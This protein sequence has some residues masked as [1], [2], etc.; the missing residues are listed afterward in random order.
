MTL[1]PP[2]TPPF[3]STYGNNPPEP[4][5][6]THSTSF[7][8]APERRRHRPPRRLA[9]LMERLRRRDRQIVP[10]AA[11]CAAAVDG[12]HPE[13]ALP[14]CR[15][16]RGPGGGC[17]RS[18]WEPDPRSLGLRSHQRRCGC[19]RCFLEAAALRYEACRKV[20]VV[21]DHACGLYHKA[22]SL[23]CHL[24][25]CPNCEPQRQARIRRAFAD[26][27]REVPADELTAL[28]LT[29]VNPPFGALAAGLRRH[30]RDLARLRRTPVF[31][32]GKCA[33][34][35]HPAGYEHRR[36]P[37]GL[38][39]TECP[40]SSRTPATWNLHTNAIVHARFVAEW[41]EL[42]WW[43]RRAT[44]A[45]HRR[46]PGPCPRH[47]TS[48]LSVGGYPRRC[49]KC[50][51]PQCAG[52][53]WDL[54]VERLRKLEETIKYV[55]KPAALLGIG[56]APFVEFLLARRHMKFASSWGAWYRRDLAPDDDV[57]EERVRV[58]L[59]PWA[60]VRLPKRCAVVGRDAE[61]ESGWTELVARAD[62]E[63]VNG[64]LVWRGEPP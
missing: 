55:T 39:S 49:P 50:G 58:W 5:G 29:A 20:R 37:A 17:R 14:V 12:R 36:V 30:K 34:P 28:V 32:G 41:D 18:W 3:F 51:V 1:S 9:P 43:W 60:S 10:M 46:C 8:W 57:A 59:D 42:S 27:L 23:S 33:W 31:A 25:G 2:L 19:A 56:L 35:K 13:L 64:A 54:R 53:A 7:P 24:P 4:H 40:P 63:L 11:A 15:C 44:C 21:L 38:W 16:P 62:L 22:A 61:Y 26:L 6:E 45:K 48:A 52:G 47:G